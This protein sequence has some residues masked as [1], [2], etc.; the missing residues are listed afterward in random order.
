[1]WECMLSHADNKRWS[2]VGRSPEEAID[3][4][5]REL[6]RRLYICGGEAG[7]RMTCRRRDNPDMQVE[8]NV[9]EGKPRAVA[10]LGRQVS[11]YSLKVMDLTGAV[12][13]DELASSEEDALAQISATLSSCGIRSTACHLVRR[14]AE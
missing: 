7:Y 13:L 9:A 5:G 1:M 4:L 6:G 2:S 11:G 12:L 3:A 14:G 10:T 8:L